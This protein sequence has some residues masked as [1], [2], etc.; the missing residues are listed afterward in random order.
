MRRQ[1]LKLNPGWPLAARLK[2]GPDTNGFEA[3]SAG[4]C[5]FLHQ[6]EPK[7]I[8]NKQHHEKRTQF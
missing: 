8:D 7:V 6:N 5:N 3:L 1:G 4:D 2:P